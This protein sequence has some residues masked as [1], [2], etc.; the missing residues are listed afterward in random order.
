M[1]KINIYFEDL[2]QVAQ[3]TLREAGS[4]NSHNEIVD[5]ETAQQVWS[6]KQPFAREAI[7]AMMKKISSSR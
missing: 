6:I 2:K 3:Q 7:D 1:A 5:L 4:T